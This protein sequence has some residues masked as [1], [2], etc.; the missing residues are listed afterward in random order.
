MIPKSVIVGVVLVIM[1]AMLVVSIEFFVPLS[2][3]SE[4]NS[5]GR[6]ALLKME[7]NNGLTPVDIAALSMELSSIGFTD[8][9][10]GAPEIAVKGQ[11]ITLDISANYRY[12]RLSGLFSRENIDQLMIYRKTTI[13][14]RVTN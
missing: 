1:V 5:I 9:L 8:I 14:R 12:S 7:D 13:A 2:A 10:I 11:E 4:L 3:K 6:R